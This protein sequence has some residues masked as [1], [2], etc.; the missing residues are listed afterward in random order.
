MFLQRE[1]LSHLT[2]SYITKEFRSHPDVG[3][4][5]TPTWGVKRSYQFLPLARAIL[6]F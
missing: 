2:L 3:L 1:S 6:H 5:K 4:L